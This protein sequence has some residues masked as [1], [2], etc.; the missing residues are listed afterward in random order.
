MLNRKGKRCLPPASTPRQGARDLSRPPLHIFDVIMSPYSFFWGAWCRNTCSCTKC[1]LSIE[2]GADRNCF[3]SWE[4]SDAPCL[5]LQLAVVSTLSAGRFM[6]QS[7]DY[8]KALRLTEARRRCAK[9]AAARQL[10]YIQK[11]SSNKSEQDKQ[12][13]V[14]TC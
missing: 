4:N 5:W 14:E 6:E 11:T 13:E 3:D 12:Q 2:L 1:D 10:I 8:A 9:G 7:S